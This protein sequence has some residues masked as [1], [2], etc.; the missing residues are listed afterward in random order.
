MTKLPRLTIKKA[1]ALAIRE[2]GTA[3]GLKREAGTPPDIYIYKMSLGALRVR[4]DN[5]WFA[6]NGLFKLMIGTGFGQDIIKYF[7]PKTLDEDFAA[8][9]LERIARRREQYEEF[10]CHLGIDGCR[11]IIEAAG[12]K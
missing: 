2:L 3:R 10:V 9:D 4:L 1:E 6:H 7:N 5:G 11:K 12:Q 8:F